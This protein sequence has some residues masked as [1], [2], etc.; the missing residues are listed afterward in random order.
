MED[1]LS[2]V[3]GVVAGAGEA[4]A[5]GVDAPVLGDDKLLPRLRVTC[6]ALANQLDKC[7]VCS[8]LIWGTLQLRL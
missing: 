4:V 1:F 5:D 3:L 2:E 6:H 8:F 7:F